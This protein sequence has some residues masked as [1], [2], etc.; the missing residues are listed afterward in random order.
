MTLVQIRY[1]HFKYF[2]LKASIFIKKGYFWPSLKRGNENRNGGN[3]FKK[4]KIILSLKFS[5]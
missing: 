3:L 2:Q 5:L 4:R 1:N